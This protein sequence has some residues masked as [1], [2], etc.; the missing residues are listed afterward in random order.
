MRLED[1]RIFLLG[2]GLPEKYIEKRVTALELEKIRRYNELIEKINY[3]AYKKKEIDIDELNARLAEFVV[4][5]DVLEAKLALQVFRVMPKPRPPP[6]ERL[7]ARKF[8]LQWRLKRYE[9]TL[10][11]TT[12]LV[13]ERREVYETMITRLE[14]EYEIGPEER[15]PII[16]LRIEEVKERW[17]VERTRFEKRIATLQIRI[18]EIRTELEAIKERLPS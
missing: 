3:E 2:L 6:I 14:A 13:K 4:Q 10:A 12:A 16:A 8:R 15:K 18:D 9:E 5:P 11:Y 1:Y 7:K 17:N